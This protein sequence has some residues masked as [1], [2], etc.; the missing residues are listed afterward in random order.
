[1]PARNVVLTAAI[2]LLYSGLVFA[3]LI[4]WRRTI[5]PSIELE[6][7][8][9][10]ANEKLGEERNS[11]YCVE[12]LLFASAPGESKDG[13]WNLLFASADGSVKFASVDMTGKCEL[14]SWKFPTEIKTERVMKVRTLQEI[15][16]FMD[17]TF[18]NEF[19]DFEVVLDEQRSSLTIQHDVRKYEYYTRQP[20]GNFSENLISEWGP[21]VDGFLIVANL[22]DRVEESETKV[23]E[24]H[25]YW[26][27]FVTYY[28]SV[29]ESKQ[30]Q[31]RA[32]WG[33]G[34]SSMRLSTEILS[35]FK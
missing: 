35:A 8:L 11:R 20:G 2:A 6:T 15:K 9:K 18:K 32:K 17:D 23:G 28:D 22:V 10:L 30:I 13:T 24:T 1:M 31:V 19:A 16:S 4:P 26:N 5:R 12:A 27:E 33:L 29:E 7:A 25:P 34:R 14:K 21:N 3:T